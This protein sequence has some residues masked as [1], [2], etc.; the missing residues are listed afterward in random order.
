MNLL[1]DLLILGL[2]A[3]LSIK[4]WK[5]KHTQ[6]YA[7]NYDDQLRSDLP[8]LE[9]DESVGECELFIDESTVTKYC[10]IEYIPNNAI[11]ERNWNEMYI[12][13]V[14]LFLTLLLSLVLALKKKDKR[15]DNV[16]DLETEGLGVLPIQTQYKEQLTMPSSLRNSMFKEKMS[17]EHCDTVQLFV[18]E[19]NV[20]TKWSCEYCGV[21]NDNTSNTCLV[22]H[23]KK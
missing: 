20:S 8:E 21:E 12:I 11:T 15:T 22:C 14:L 1:L 10:V 17:K 4:M 19:E 5:R 6:T 23:H 13:G 9:N 18:Q 2:I 7:E 3:I 16:P